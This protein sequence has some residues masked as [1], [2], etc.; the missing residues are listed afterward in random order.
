[1]KIKKQQ[2]NFTQIANDLLNDSRIS[3]KAK[4]IYSYIFSKPDN[5]DFSIERIQDDFTDGVK[6][7]SSGIKELE[8]Y[9]YLKREKQSNGRN[10]YFVYQ[11]S[12]EIA[13]PSKTADSQNVKKPKR[14]KDK[15][16]GISNKE[17]IKN[18][19]E[20]SNKDTTTSSSESTDSTNSTDLSLLKDKRHEDVQ[21]IIDVIV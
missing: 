20:I 18:K 4:G 9:G 21:A 16:E 19:E 15:T 8:K 14:Q 2:V 1:M 10:I 7:L 12:Q 5:W 3:A 11:T 6:A 13:L 17:N